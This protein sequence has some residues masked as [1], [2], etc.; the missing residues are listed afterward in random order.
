MKKL[1]TEK[2]NTVNSNLVIAKYQAEY[3]KKLD[4]NIRLS[5]QNEKLMGIIQMAFTMD[6]DAF[7]KDFVIEEVED[8]GTN[9]K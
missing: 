3:V 9:N 6:P 1:D 2:L 4:E 5:A 7:P 8:N